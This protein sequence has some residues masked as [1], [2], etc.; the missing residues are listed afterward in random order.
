MCYLPD[1]TL[2]KLKKR[3]DKN[4]LVINSQ[5]FNSGEKLV[6]CSRKVMSFFNKL[7][8]NSFLGNMMAQTNNSKDIYAGGSGFDISSCTS[9]GGTAEGLERIPPMG[10]ASENQVL[11][12]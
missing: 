1:D 7:G 6:L 9:A 3:C 5:I 4:G 2:A 12:Q 11:T 8:S 10:L